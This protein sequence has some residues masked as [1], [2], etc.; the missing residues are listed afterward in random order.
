MSQSYGILI[1]LASVAF[2]LSMQS[3]IKALQGEVPPGEVVFFRALL[4]IPFLLIWIGW[5]GRLFVVLKTEN[6]PGNILRGVLGACAMGLTF[7]AIS[8]LPLPEAT[9]IFYVAPILTTIFAA[10]FLREPVRLIRLAAVGVGLLGVLVILWPRL[11]SVFESGATEDTI[12]AFGAMLALGAAIFMA[13]AKILV[14]RLVG[15]DHP[16]TVVLYAAICAS[17]VTLVSAPFGWVWPT[18]EQWVLLLGAGM[19][20][21][22]GQALLTTAYKYAD[23]STIAPFDYSSMI[24]AILF[25]YVFFAEWPTV[26]TLIGAAI[27][28]SAGGV[29]LWRETRL[30]VETAKARRA[31]PTGS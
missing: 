3:L 23:A 21:A 9:A 5:Q 27:V 15:K 10:I 12:L 11:G 20:G 2:I 28:I 29:I 22:I 30:G 14:R 13:V 24:F 7:A 26:Q 4:S 1:K 8:Y 25:G 16:S 19:F 31:S 18:A 17:V 6:L